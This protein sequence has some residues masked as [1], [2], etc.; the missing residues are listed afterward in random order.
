MYR[1][2][3]IPLDGRGM[4]VAS[5]CVCR[6]PRGFT[7]IAT[8]VNSDERRP[9]PAKQIKPRNWKRFTTIMNWHVGGRLNGM[10]PLWGPSKRAPTVERWAAAVSLVEGVLYFAP[11]VAASAASLGLFGARVHTSHFRRT[12]FEIWTMIIA[13]RIFWSLVSVIHLRMLFIGDGS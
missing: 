13:R 3:T 9:M 8:Y 12:R 11:R 4:C 10:K 1:N 5:H 2:A 6:S 7:A